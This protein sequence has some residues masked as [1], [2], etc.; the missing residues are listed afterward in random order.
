MTDEPRLTKNFQ[1]SNTVF[2][3]LFSGAT[4]EEIHAF[5]YFDGRRGTGRSDDLDWLQ[6]QRKHKDHDEKGIVSVLLYAY[7]FDLPV[8][9]QF[10]ILNHKD[11]KGQSFTKLIF[12]VFLSA[13]VT[14]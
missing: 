9:C 10:E 3:S 13:F 1:S 2:P 4:Q 6:F 11:S 5:Y 7:S 8:V 12:F 14:S